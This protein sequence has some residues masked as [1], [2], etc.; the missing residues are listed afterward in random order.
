M[1]RVP[2]L[3]DNA[4]YYTDA[5]FPRRTRF[6][7]VV[8]AADRLAE[9]EGISRQALDDVA[10]VSQKRAGAAEADA[11]LMASRIPLGTLT[12]DE[13]VRAQQTTAESLQGMAP[14]FVALAAQYAEALDGPIDHRHTIAHAPPICDGAGLALIGSA[15]GSAD[16]P[17]HES[18][19]TPSRAATRTRRCWPDSRPWTAF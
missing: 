11:T 13:C 12:K 4:S 14:S 8:L 6:I 5:S 9:A 1:S 10:L 17:A 19:P 2:F 3:G 7:P 15:P 18:W 16:N